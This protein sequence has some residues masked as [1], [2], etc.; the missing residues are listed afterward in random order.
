[1]I[2]DVERRHSIDAQTRRSIARIRRIEKSGCYPRMEIV[3]R[4]AVAART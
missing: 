2:V 3:G 4:M 1:M